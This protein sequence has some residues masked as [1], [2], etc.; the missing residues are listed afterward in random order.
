MSAGAAFA[1]ILDVMLP[2]GGYAVALAQVYIDESYD[3]TDEPPFIHIAGYLFRKQKAKEFTATWGSYLKMKGLPYFH[4]QECAPNP[5]RGPFEGRSD[6]DEIVR[7]LIAL[8]KKFSA[9][10]FAVTVARADYE[11]IG[12][13][14]DGMPRSA[15]VFA[16][17]AAMN[18]IRRWTERANFKGEIA[19]FFEC[20][21]DDR[22]DAHDFMRWMFSGE[23]VKQNYSYAGHAFVKKATPGLHPAD[24]LAWFWNAEVARRHDPKRKPPRK[25]FLAL[26]R[27]QDFVIEYDLPALQGLATALQI[28]E[29]RRAQVMQEVLTGA[30]DTADLPPL[31]RR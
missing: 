18:S 10:G 30:R 13:P 29:E 14:R 31:K 12:G 6:R 9:F 25:D 4:M 28:A 19:Y 24:M 1:D 7:K 11:R 8:T 15:Y 16:L 17:F 21:H 20:G 26:V 23:R 5:G 2:R 3:G 22:G 27:D